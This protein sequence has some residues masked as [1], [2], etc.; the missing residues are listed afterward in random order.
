MIINCHVI[1]NYLT[2]SRWGN[3]AGGHG[4]IFFMLAL[5]N[6]I[7]CIMYSRSLAEQ[8]RDFVQ[9]HSQGFHVFESFASEQDVGGLLEA[10]TSSSFEPNWVE[11]HNWNGNVTAAKR[12]MAPAP[13]CA[14]LFFENSIVPVLKTRGFYT[15]K[16]DLRLGR[17]VAVLRYLSWCVAYLR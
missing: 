5:T 11:I 3:G 8:R 9:F 17:G 2:S 13:E 7:I 6:P 14:Q 12:W 1:F 4:R 16:H 15:T 10:V